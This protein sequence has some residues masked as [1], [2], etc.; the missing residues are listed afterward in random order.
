MGNIIDVASYI[1]NN[2]GPMTTMKLQ[3]LVFYSQAHALA[4]SGTPLFDDNFQ[5]WRGG[6]VA[7]SLY[8]HHRRMLIIREDDL[9][10]ADVSKLTSTERYYI[11]AVCSELAEVSGNALSERTHREAP[12]RAARVGLAE[13]A[14][15]NQ[16]IEQDSIREYYRR[17][18][19]V[20]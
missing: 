16:I 14:L 11:D 4:S 19:V 6:P 2:Y 8:R 20:S 17:N 7:P 12:W 3:K 1:L 10:K 13:N 15:G 18:P 5:A 9:G